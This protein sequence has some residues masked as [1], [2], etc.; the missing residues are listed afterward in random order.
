MKRSVTVIIISLL[1][2][3][4]LSCNQIERD[5]NI[6]GTSKFEITLEKVQYSGWRDFVSNNNYVFSSVLFGKQA[7]SKYN[8]V[9]NTITDVCLKPGC[10]H[11][12][13]TNVE[14]GG[15]PVPK[16]L[17][18]QFTDGNK[19][20][21]TYDVAIADE[22]ALAEADA[23]GSGELTLWN[24]F[25]S[26]DITT[27]EYREIIKSNA[28]DFDPLFNFIYR[29]GKIY[30]N[31]YIPSKEHPESEEDYDLCLCSMNDDGS[32][33]EILIN[34]STFDEIIPGMIPDPLAIV[35]DKVWFTSNETGQLFSIDISQMDLHYLVK[36]DDGFLG[37]YDGYGTFL[38]D[39]YI[40]F[41]RYANDVDDSIPMYSAQIAYRVNCETGIIEKLFDDYVSW[42]FVT[43]NYVY[44]EMSHEQPSNENRDK[45]G[46][47]DVGTHLH[48]I[49]KTDHNGNLLKTYSFREDYTTVIGV[50]GLGEKL[51]FDA[52]YM[53]EFKY[54]PEKGEMEE[55]CIVFNLKDET[56]TEIGRET[57]PR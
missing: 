23:G 36:G 7:V 16:N 12:S 32:N 30:F 10:D 41:E 57:G 43:D 35:G 22:D 13:R 9:T 28:S 11:R 52:G 25:V 18:F 29:E 8:I 48:I 33:Q 34:Y 21:Y 50:W 54:G 44:Y 17:F 39:N 55:F 40:Y 2:I 49:K 51:F 31:R 42:I 37:L 4:L 5:N 46:G 3:S 56:I 47:D 19:V 6:D 53:D 14:S 45:V 20:Y 15:C 38:V 27:G 26:Y 1:I 24:Y